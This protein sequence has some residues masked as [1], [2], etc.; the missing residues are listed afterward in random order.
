[1][2]FS[3]VYYNKRNTTQ[4]TADKKFLFSCCNIFQHSK[5]N[6]V[7]P[8]DHVISTVYVLAGTCQCLGLHW[9]LPN[10]PS[11]AKKR[12]LTSLHL[13]QNHNPNFLCVPV[14][15]LLETD[16]LNALPSGETKEIL[17]LCMWWQD[18]Y[19][20]QESIDK[21]WIPDLKWYLLKHG[22]KTETT[23]CKPKNE[24]GNQLKAQITWISHHH[25]HQG[26]RLL[27]LPTTLYLSALNSDSLYIAII[28]FDKRNT[29]TDNIPW[30][31]FS[32]SE[33]KKSVSSKI[34][35]NNT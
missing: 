8:P 4:L 11:F 19:F 17:C 31:V 15:S 25:H 28:L 35:T 14:H 7:P 2:Y 16:L 29:F 5:R 13:N 20:T 1:M 18:L 12:T 30:A 23:L 24:E 26:P 10:I 6:S 34:M 22:F 9:F 21:W 33:V 27:R 3:G 32:G